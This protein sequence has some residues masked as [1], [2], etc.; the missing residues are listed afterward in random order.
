M[1]NEKIV[2]LAQLNTVKTYIDTKDGQA[3]KSIGYSNN[4]LNFVNAVKLVKRLLKE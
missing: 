4:T 1:A 2:S 3:I